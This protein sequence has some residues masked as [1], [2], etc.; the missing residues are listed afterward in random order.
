MKI[1]FE[2]KLPDAA[3]FEQMMNGTASAAEQYSLFQRH[4]EEIVAAYDGEKLVGVGGKRAE[5]WAFVIHPGYVTRDIEHNM[6]K[7]ACW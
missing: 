4:G 3:A 1:A 2:K 5:Q 7:L 6:K